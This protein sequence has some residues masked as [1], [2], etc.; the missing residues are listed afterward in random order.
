MSKRYL[1]TSFSD[2][3]K[4]KLYEIAQAEQPQEEK[5]LE[6]ENTD[7]ETAQEDSEGET[8]GNTKKKEHKVGSKEYMDDWKKEFEEI[9]NG[10]DNLYR[11][12]N[13]R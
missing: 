1:D 2:F 9:M 5:D 8:D 10:Y 3:L 7:K 11:N 6:E 4:H 12:K 13:R